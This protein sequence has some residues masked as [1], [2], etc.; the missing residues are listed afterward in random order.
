V[1]IEREKRGKNTP[2]ET[3]AAVLQGLLSDNAGMPFSF[4]FRQPWPSSQKSNSRR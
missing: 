1:K 3:G 4:F 2:K